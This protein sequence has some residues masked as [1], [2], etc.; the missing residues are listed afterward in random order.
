[1]NDDL[2]F[3]LGLGFF[4]IAIGIAIYLKHLTAC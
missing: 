3:L 4:Y 1:M 2:Q